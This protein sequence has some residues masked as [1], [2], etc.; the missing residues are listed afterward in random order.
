MNLIIDNYDSFTYNL[1]QYIGAIDS[2]VEVYR[3]DEITVR[4]VA[5]KKPDHII[6]SPGPKYPK[7]AGICIDLIKSLYTEIPI[8]GVCLGHQSIGEA[9]GGKTVRAPRL[10]HGKADKAKILSKTSLLFSGI[11][12]DEIQVGRYHSLV[13]DEVSLPGFMLVTAKCGDGSVMAMEHRDYPLYG[14][15]FHPESV[16]TPDGMTMLE[17]F[18]KI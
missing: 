11:A 3:N 1:Y 18:L 17:N 10:M 15:Q 16:L 13:T 14:V 4:E 8:L 6:I 9:M 7:D 12:G 2:D 5:A